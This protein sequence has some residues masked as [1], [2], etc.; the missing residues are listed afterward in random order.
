M[1]PPSPII[2]IA[3]IAM[4]FSTVIIAKDLAGETSNKRWGITT[5]EPIEDKTEDQKP[6]KKKGKV[7]D[8]NEQIKIEPERSTSEEAKGSDQKGES[9]GNIPQKDKKASGKDAQADKSGQ[10]KIN[11]IKNEGSLKIQW[12]NKKQK[13]TCET[14]LG[15]L[16]EHFLKARYYSIQGVPCGTAENARSF[17][18]LV[19]SCKRDCPEGF[20]KKHG[21]T[22]RII[23]NLSWLE[24][25]GAERCPDMNSN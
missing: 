4:V 13:T 22:T 9:D 10:P 18:V 8:A 3:I 25:L 20:L 16:K 7:E 1:K 6:S 19:D 21:Y 12:K 11:D 15:Q 23:R 14:H 2:A 24:K 5:K 17:L